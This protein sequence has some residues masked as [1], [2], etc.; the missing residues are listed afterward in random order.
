MAKSSMQ[1]RVTTK[2]S[3]EGEVVGLLRWGI[4]AGDLRP[5]LA[6]IVWVGGGGLGFM[7]VILGISGG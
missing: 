2:G 3:D 7:I 5:V 4:V 1:L 6:L